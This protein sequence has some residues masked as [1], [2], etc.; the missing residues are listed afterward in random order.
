MFRYTVTQEHAQRIFNSITLKFVAEYPVWES[1]SATRKDLLEGMDIDD[2][3]NDF[4]ETTGQ[5]QFLM[6]LHA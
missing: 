6:L 4:T 1:S 5:P 2:G 3:K